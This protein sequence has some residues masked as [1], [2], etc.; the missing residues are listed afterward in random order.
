MGPALRV[1][2]VATKSPWPPVGGGNVAL[3]ALLAALTDRGV[4]V[5]VVAPGPAASEDRAAG[6]PIRTV[7]LRPR[8]W[9]AVMPNLVSGLPPALARFRLPALGRAVEEEIDA[10]APDVVHV[11]QLHLA[12]LLP[13]AARRV[14]VLL[15]QQNVESLL[16]RRLATVRR[17]PWSAL[18][19]REAGRVA[20]LESRACRSAHVVAAISERDAGLLRE[21]APGSRVR[22]LPVPFAAGP[23]AVGVRLAGD[24]PLVALGSFDWA[25]NRDG[26]AWFLRRVWPLLRLQAPRAVLHLAGPGSASLVPRGRPGIVAHGVIARAEELHDPRATVLIPL[27]VGSGVR[28]RLL[29]AWAAGI[30]AVT[31]GPGGEGLVEKDGDG[32]VLAADDTGFAAAVV[33]LASDGALRQRLVARG[34][35]R[36]AAH[37]PRRVADRAE[38]L[39]REAIAAGPPR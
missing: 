34:R 14:P 11:E 12:W 7:P 2:A 29:E 25:P 24:P 27:R 20:I 33:Q 9:L 39:Y 1:L 5:R 18:L 10:F 13:F 17:L 26:I 15:R 36:L 23:P 4:D 28:L 8:S 21:L 19:R 22:A 37:D 30:P 16:L 35:E 32:A 3:H 6:Y 31:T 38:E